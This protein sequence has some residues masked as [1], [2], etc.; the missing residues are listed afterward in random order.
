MTVRRLWALTVVA[1][2]RSGPRP[3][4]ARDLASIRAMRARDSAATL[5]VDT[6]ALMA[7]WT[8]DIV[9]LQPGSPVRRGA[10]ANAAALRE[11]AAQ[12]AA[13]RNLA[14]RF[15]FDEVILLD[16]HAV[17]W[18]TFAGAT[19]TPS[20]DTIRVARKFMRVLRR[21]AA[22]EWRIARTIYHTDPPN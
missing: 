20:G 4:E 16:D 12:A 11:Y 5:A 21:S 14:V 3:D 2:C 19:L 1:A 6:T 13:F 10:A 17:E 18:G 15:Q 22:G 9:A 7:L 8:D